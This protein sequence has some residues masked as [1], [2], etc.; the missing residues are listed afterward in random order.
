MISIFTI[1]PAPAPVTIIFPTERIIQSHTGVLY[2]E[3]HANLLIAGRCISATH[4]AQASIRIMPIVC[5]LGEAAGTAAALAAE[6]GRSVSEV[7]VM[8]L[9]A[10]LKKNGAFIGES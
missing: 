4:E 2:P 10:I 6:D 5:T 8:Q 1:R 3:M 7:D 9:R